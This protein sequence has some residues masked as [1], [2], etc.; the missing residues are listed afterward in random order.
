VEVA[1]GAFFN[2][3]D[4]IYPINVNFEHKKLFPG[5]LGPFVGEMGSLAYWS[6]PNKLFRATLERMLP[7]LREC[8]Y[9]GFIDI[10]CIVNG[11][12]I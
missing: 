6:N 12:G 10:N 9:V 11:S 7:A 8:R 5:N 2:G 4:F 1:V 3:K